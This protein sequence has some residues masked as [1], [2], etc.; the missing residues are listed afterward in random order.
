MTADST[1]DNTVGEDLLRLYP[2]LLDQDAAVAERALQAI[3]QGVEVLR[4]FPFTCRK[5][6]ERNPFL[7][8]LIVSFEVSGYVALFEI[9]SDQQVTIL[10]IRLQREDDY[11]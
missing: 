5:A 4:S 3:R 10:A 6:A 2:F 9:E 7:R 1:L 11:Y 8:E